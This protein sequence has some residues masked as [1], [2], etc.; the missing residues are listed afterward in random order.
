[1]YVKLR[2]I[3]PQIQ[4]FGQT[5]VVKDEFHVSLVSVKRLIPQIAENHRITPEQ[6]EGKV[7]LTLIGLLD[8]VDLI[9][10]GFIDDFR[11]A[12]EDD[13]K[14]IIRTCRVKGIQTFQ[15]ELQKELGVEIPAQPTHVTLYRLAH[16]KKGI[17]I[18]SKE[19]L[20]RMTTPIAGKEL[21]IVKKATKL[22]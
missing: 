22:T 4:L 6:A 1:M 13:K 9:F 19:D 20:A 18:W 2:K 12:Q 8:R 11:L 7:L 10:D 16:D 17:G 14:T 5:F 21:E 3:Q 15:K